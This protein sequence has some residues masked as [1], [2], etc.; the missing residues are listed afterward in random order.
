MPVKPLYMTM[1]DMVDKWGEELMGDYGYSAVGA[2]VGATYKN[3]GSVVLENDIPI[4]FSDPRIWRT[5]SYGR[6]Y[7]REF[8]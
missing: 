1:A 7:C 6:R 2:V 5:G 3:R 8:R 4:C